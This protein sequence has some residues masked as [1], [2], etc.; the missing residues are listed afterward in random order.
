VYDVGAGCFVELG[1]FFD[2]LRNGDIS[3]SYLTC[4]YARM[5]ASG[6]SGNL[7]MTDALLNE[8]V[9]YFVNGV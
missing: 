3:L 4:G 2:C 9:R 5:E 6:E 8:R 7:V 1:I